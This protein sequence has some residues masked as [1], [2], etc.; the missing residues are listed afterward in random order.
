VGNESA[1]LEQQTLRFTPQRSPNWPSLLVLRVTRGTYVEFK[2]LRHLYSDWLDRR[3]WSLGRFWQMSDTP[4][5]KIASWGLL[6]LYVAW[7]KS[8]G[9]PRFVSFSKLVQTSH[10]FGR[11]VDSHSFVCVLSLYRCAHIHHY[12][13]YAHTSGVKSLQIININQNNLKIAQ[14]RNRS[15][16]TTHYKQYLAHSESLYSNASTYSRLDGPPHYDPCDSASL[17]LTSLI[18]RNTE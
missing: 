7:D 8:S 10:S 9:S 14:S 2:P 12:L 17:G 4:S 18:G 13:Q 1:N 3:S 11:L 6:S 15:Q 5:R 16:P